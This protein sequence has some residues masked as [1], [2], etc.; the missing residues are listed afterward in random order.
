MAIDFFGHIRGL[1]NSAE[2]LFSGVSDNHSS[3]APKESTKDSPSVASMLNLV[4]SE[5]D[6][7]KAGVKSLADLS[8]LRALR[9]PEDN[10]RNL[11]DLNRQAMVSVNRADPQ[12][13]NGRPNESVDPNQMIAAWMDRLGAFIRTKREQTSNPGDK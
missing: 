11:Y 13:R 5:T 9:K 4:P 7:A 8:S 2:D 10:M 1:Y 3:D 12:T 6:V